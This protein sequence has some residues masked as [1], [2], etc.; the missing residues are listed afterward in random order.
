MDAGNE[1]FVLHPGE[2]ILGSTYEQITLDDDI[3][4]RLKKVIAGP[5][6]LLTHSQPGSLTGFTGHVTPELSNTATMPILLK[7]GQL[8]FFKLSSV[9]EAP[10][11]GARGSRYRASAACFAFPPKL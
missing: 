1:P 10:T 6:R 4:A 9:A 7:G 2:F 3:A 11:V 5:P 8:C